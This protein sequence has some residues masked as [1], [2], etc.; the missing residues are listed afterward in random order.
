[1]IDLHKTILFLAGLGSL[2]MVAVG[3]SQIPSQPTEIVSD[4]NQGAAVSAANNQ[5]IVN[6]RGFIIAMIGSGSFLTTIVV[7][8]YLFSDICRR[9]DIVAEVKPAIRDIKIV[10]V[11]PLVP[12]AVAPLVPVASPVEVKDVKP[13]LKVIRAPAAPRA[14]RAPRAPVVFAHRPVQGPVCG[15]VYGREYGPVYGTIYGHK[16]EVY[17][18][19]IAQRYP[20]LKPTV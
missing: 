6:S 7:C 10:S 12:V 5:Y 17:R 11:A 20:Q 18:K 13:I 15:P 19:S 8:V 9:E 1:M 2:I 3:L 16:A 4:T 14:P